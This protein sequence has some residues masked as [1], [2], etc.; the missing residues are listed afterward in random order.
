MSIIF[1]LPDAICADLI[2]NWWFV[3]DVIKLTSA[4]AVVALEATNLYDLLGQTHISLVNCARNK[5]EN[6]L[7]LKEY[8]Y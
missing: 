2:S 4:F 3:S 8:G 6:E 7:Y 5:E 1:R